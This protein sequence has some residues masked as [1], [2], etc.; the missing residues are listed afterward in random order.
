MSARVFKFCI[1]NEDN[2]VYYCKQNQGAELYFCLLLFFLF[3]ISHSN[4][5]KAPEEEKPSKNHFG[6]PPV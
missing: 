4:V 3:S 5:V 6:W 2:K 1:H